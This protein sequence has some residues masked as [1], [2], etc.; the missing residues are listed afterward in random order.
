MS[1]LTYAERLAGD[2][3][4]NL[5][6][7]CKKLWLKLHHQEVMDYY[8]LHGLEMTKRR[9][10]FLNITMDDLFPD[11]A[12]PKK[13][14]PYTMAL[15]AEQI[16]ELEGRVDDLV[17]WQEKTIIYVDMLQGQRSELIA[18]VKQVE[19]E[20]S[21]FQDFIKTQLSQGVMQLLNTMLT[22]EAPD[23]GAVTHLLDKPDALS[24]ANLLGEVSPSL[25][26]ATPKGRESD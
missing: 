18:R 3:P 20:Y 16:K 17:S 14:R 10:H 13:Q 8:A 5:K 25:E 21:E 22:G 26:L 2:D 11:S 24:V 1:E 15:L 7:G 19:Q 6:G 23:I 12:R 9:F 4:G